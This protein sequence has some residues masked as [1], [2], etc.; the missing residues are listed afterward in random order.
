MLKS[1]SLRNSDDCDS[2]TSQISLIFLYVVGNSEVNV[3]F[4]HKHHIS[5]NDQ[6]FP[7]ESH[8]K[9]TWSDRNYDII[10]REKVELHWRCHSAY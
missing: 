4:F 7:H 9:R 8:E 3:S 1:K 2:S 10:S 5:K 6:F